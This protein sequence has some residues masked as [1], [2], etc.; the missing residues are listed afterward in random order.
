MRSSTSAMR[1]SPCSE[2]SLPR[3]TS[4]A[5]CPEVTLRASS[6]PACTSASSMSLSTT[7]MPAAAIVWAICPPI[8][9]APTTADLNTN[10][11]GEPS[12][13]A[14]SEGSGQARGVLRDVLGYVLGD[15]LGDRPPAADPLLQKRFAG[16]H[17]Q[18]TGEQEP[19]AGVAVLFA[20][21]GQLAGLLDALGERPD[22][23]RLA[24]LGEE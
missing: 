20:Q 4:L 1:S 6:S 19:L 24:Q 14:W 7:G 15:V 3:S 5:T 17:V 18:G 16:V 11:V 9:P 8:V 22:R 10:M 21:Q 2:V 13:P 23:Q 12:A